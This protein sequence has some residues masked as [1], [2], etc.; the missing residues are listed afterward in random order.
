MQ[1]IE[2]FYYDILSQQAQANPDGEAIIMGD[3]R[4]T[5]SQLIAKIDSVAAALLNKGL[6]KGEKVTVK[7][8][9]SEQHF[10]QPPSR[11]TEASLV[12]TLEENGIGRP[13]TYAP[14]ISTIISRGYVS[15]EKKRLF[16]TLLRRPT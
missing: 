14:T 4:L 5:Y 2:K 16:S 9:D 12:R 10:T 15:R 8:V 3:T 13:S 1:T 6:K 7:K 11:Y